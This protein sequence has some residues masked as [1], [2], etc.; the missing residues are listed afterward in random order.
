MCRTTVPS[1]SAACADKAG[2]A[3]EF[4]G[5][6]LYRFDHPDV[7]ADCAVGLRDLVDVDAALAGRLPPQPDYDIDN[8]GI[9]TPADAALLAVPASGKRELSGKRG[10]SG[11]RGASRKPRR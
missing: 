1:A 9:L 4:P 10:S 3:A 6:G 5:A 8:D 2:N 7:D 11:K